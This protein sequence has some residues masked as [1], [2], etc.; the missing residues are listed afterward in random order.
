[1]DGWKLLRQIKLDSFDPR[2]KAL[3][4]PKPRPCSSPQVLISAWI[5]T[6]PKIVRPRWHDWR[7]D[8]GLLTYLFDDFLLYSNGLFRG[9]FHF[10]FS[11]RSPLLPP[12]RGCFG[13]QTFCVALCHCVWMLTVCCFKESFVRW[14][15]QREQICTAC[16]SE[17]FDS[18]FDNRS[19]LRFRTLTTHGW[20]SI[21]E[22]IT[23]TTR[24]RR[25]VDTCI[26]TFLPL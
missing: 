4:D 8:K 14:S 2:I 20:L 25:W 26:D 22:F 16:L 5:S 13:G 1:M 11:H 15:W 24:T 23:T 10:P 9:D 12:S 3:P 18:A 7:T 17:D 21:P 19:D 6:F